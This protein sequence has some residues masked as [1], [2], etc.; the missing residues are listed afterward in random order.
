MSKLIGWFTWSCVWLRE[1]INNAGVINQ[2]NKD[3]ISEWN[4]SVINISEFST[5]VM[6]LMK[7]VNKEYN[8]SLCNIYFQD[9]KQL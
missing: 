7:K 6:H 9:I 3:T 8:T 5:R 2:L 1:S 4:T